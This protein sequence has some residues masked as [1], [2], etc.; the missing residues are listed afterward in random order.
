MDENKT[1]VAS[2]RCLRHVKPFS[3]LEAVSVCFFVA[4][5]TA[6]WG[7]WNWDSVASGYATT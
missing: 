2:D 4:Y 7:D 3:T 5:L 6:A 1:H